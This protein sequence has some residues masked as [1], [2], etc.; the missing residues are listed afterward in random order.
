MIIGL[1]GLNFE[2]ILCEIN[3]SLEVLSRKKLSRI[4]PFY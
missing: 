3:V 2:A 4:G 1:Q